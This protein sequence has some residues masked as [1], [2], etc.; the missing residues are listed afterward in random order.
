M[1]KYWKIAVLVICFII[2]LLFI[3]P[4]VTHNI[5]SFMCSNGY[6]KPGS[7]NQWIGFYGAVIGGALTLLGVWWTIYY[8]NQK[9]KS[10]NQSIAKPI[11]DLQVYFEPIKIPR[12]NVKLKTIDKYFG[13]RSSDSKV[14]YFIKITNTSLISFNNFHVTKSGLFANEN[15][16][17]THEYESPYSLSPGESRIYRLIIHYSSPLNKKTV[18]AWFNMNIVFFDIYYLKKEYTLKISLPF[19]YDKNFLLI[20]EIGTITKAYHEIVEN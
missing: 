12:D 10:K 8:Q 2:S 11:F 5:V 17:D 4:V 16:F 20:H 14:S 13:D 9:E 7:E 15:E 1:K 19:Y 6:L 18:Q 3:I